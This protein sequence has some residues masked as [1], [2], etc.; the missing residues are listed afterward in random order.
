MTKYIKTAM[1]YFEKHADFN[2]LTHVLLGIG[3]GALLTYPLF[4][5]HPVRFGLLFLV[6][7]IGGHVWAATHKP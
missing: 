6:L 3:F 2:G 7:G 5:T 4:D 1:T